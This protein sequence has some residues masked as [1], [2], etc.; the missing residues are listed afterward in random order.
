[1]KRLFGCFSVLNVLK[2]N[3]VQT[4]CR[5]W[6]HI[7]LGVSAFKV[8]RYPYFIPPMTVRQDPRLKL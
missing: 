8:S 1:M 6:E 7:L 4:Y 5:D 3:N 2:L